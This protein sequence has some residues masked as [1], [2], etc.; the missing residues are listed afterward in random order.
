M[1][2]KR[3][4]KTDELNSFFVKIPER[5]RQNLPSYSRSFDEYL[6]HLTDAEF[7]PFSFS[8]PTFIQVR[9]T[10]NRMSIKKGNGLNIDL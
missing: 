9:D 5:L 10:I 2:N 7:S 8:R 6:D 4:N 3:T 1:R